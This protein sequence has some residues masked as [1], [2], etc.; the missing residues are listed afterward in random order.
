MDLILTAISCE[1]LTGRRAHASSVEPHVQPDTALE[2]VGEHPGSPTSQLASAQHNQG[3]L[4]GPRPRLIVDGHAADLAEKGSGNVRRLNTGAS[5]GKAS[6]ALGG[7]F[8]DVVR[9]PASTCASPGADHSINTADSKT[10]STGT[11]R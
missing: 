3:L 9:R 4:L 7:A 2:V 8:D 5:A 11:G 10:D 6:H 1:P